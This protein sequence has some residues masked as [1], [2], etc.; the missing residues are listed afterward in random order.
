[1]ERAH[2]VLAGSPTPFE[3]SIAHHAIGLVQREFGDLAAAIPRLRRA[4]ALARR[5]GSVPREA[6]VLAS[7]GVALVHAGRSAA[8]LSTLDEAVGKA[9]GV[10]GAR[11]R[12]RRAGARWILGWHRE[13]LADLRPA[14][15]VLRRA[16]ETIWAA[17]ALSLRGLIHLAVGAVDRAAHD[18]EH[19]ER[20]FADTDQE[21]DSAVARH[22][23][24][25]VAFRSG[26]L[27]AALS[28]FDDVERRYRALGTPMP[29]LI[30]DRCAVLLAAGLA[31]DALEA[32]DAAAGTLLRL[33]GQATKRAELLLTAAHAALAAGRPAIARDRAQAALRLFSAQRREWWRSHARLVL[34]QA[35]FAEHPA[36]PGLLRSASRT[37]AELARIGAPEVVAARLL[38]G[39]IALALDNRAYAERHLREAAR[40]RL[41]GSAIA[42][43]TGWLAK[44]LLAQAVGDRGRLLHACRRGL[45]VLNEHQL[46]LGASE[47][48]AR[49]TAHGAELA[50]L[51]QRAC[52]RAGQMRELLAWSERLRATS[53]A[54]PAV[55]PPEDR[56]A[57]RDLAALRELTSRVDKARRTGAAAGALTGELAALEQRIRARELATP[58]RRVR[59]T[60][61]G[62]FDVTELLDMLGD[63]VLLEIAGIAGEVHLVVCGAGRVRHVRAGRAADA[64]A[65]VEAARWLLRQLAHEPEPSRIPALGARLDRLTRRLETTLLGPAVRHLGD[66]PVVIVPPGRLHAVPWA[67][68]PALF[69]RTHEIAPSASAWLRARAAPRPDPQAPVV[70]VRGP[71]LATR[72][73]EVPVLAELY[74]RARVLQNGSATAAGVLDSLE[75]SALAHIAAHGRFRADNPLFSALQLDDGQLTVYELERLGRAPHRLILPSCESG[76]LQPIGADELLG[77][78]TALLPLGTAGI[79]ASLVPV[80]DPA[81][82]PFMVALHRSLSRGARL[83]EGLRFARCATPEDPLRRATACSF[84]ALGAA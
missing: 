3:A 23:R 8:G 53:C 76:R 12:F 21:H 52:L 68:L 35:R 82:V 40:A 42:R 61:G 25:L 2:A 48:R 66:G 51:A 28:C 10:A 56:A 55:R 18:L 74:P 57:L 36:T 20:M 59:W 78:S 80:N 27:P 34:V 19:A 81:T 44:A 16:N 37:A 29:E 33:R 24:G 38:T 60:G 41:H 77:L 9:R 6:D 31:Q 64:L 5:S 67:L 4:L 73:A 32:A 75:G 15:R 65:G 84:I 50:E 39:R 63:G 1:M 22:N 13:A 17:R 71:R 70:L 79:V 11:V 62:G 83:A 46:T 54:V 72:G 69:G 49:A 58:G 47:L 30:I 7:L 43:T 26:D 45:D 14:I